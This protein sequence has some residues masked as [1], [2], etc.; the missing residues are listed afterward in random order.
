MQGF[1][2]SRSYKVIII[3]SG[4]GGQLA[5]LSL[6]KHN[7]TDFLILE[8]RKFMGGTW[9]QNVYPG[10]AVDVPSPLY[11]VAS[12]PFDGTQM[13]ADQHELNSYTDH[14][15]EKHGLR[16]Q[17]VTNC[18]VTGIQWDE[19]SQRWLIKVANGD[20]YTARFVINASGPLSIPVI[21]HLKGRCLLARVAKRVAAIVV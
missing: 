18:N 3:G 5:A 16:E 1:K 8:R 12:E 20:A 9:S 2:L 19:S 7:I 14:I 21:P 13:Y 15:I 11:A 17:T 6:R 4:F 10:A